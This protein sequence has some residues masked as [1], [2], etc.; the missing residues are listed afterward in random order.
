MRAARTRSSRFA[1][2]AATMILLASAPASALEFPDLGLEWEGTR[3]QDVTAK[4]VDLTIVRPVASAR[5][6]VGGLLFIPAAIFSAPM[7]REGFDGALDVLIVAPAE[8]A[9][10]RE[11]GEL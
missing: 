7:G 11:I 6:A 3:A 1:C 8:Y 2:L 4:F 9:F 10:E 5:V